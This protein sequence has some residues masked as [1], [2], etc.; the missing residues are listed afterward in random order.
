MM[1]F[2]FAIVA[3]ALSA[4]GAYAMRG[5]DLMPMSKNIEVREPAAKPGFWYKPVSATT[6]K[7]ASDFGPP[8]APWGTL[9]Y[10]LPWTQRGKE[11][12]FGWYSKSFPEYHKGWA[13]TQRRI[14]ETRAGR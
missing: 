4:T 1:L 10:D 14:A 11:S 9:K 6:G 3:A 13:E 5:T 2:R 12:G 7:R 8:E